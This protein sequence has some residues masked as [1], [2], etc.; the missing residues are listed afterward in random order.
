MRVIKD[1]KLVGSLLL[2]EG[3]GYTGSIAARQRDP[4]ASDDPRCGRLGRHGLCWVLAR[5]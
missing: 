3:G 4:D 5:R 2:A 1:S